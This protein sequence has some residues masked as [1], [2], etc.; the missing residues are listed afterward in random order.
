MIPHLR[1]V[2]LGADFAKRSGEFVLSRRGRGNRGALAQQIK[3]NAG[4]INARFGQDDHVAVAIKDVE[5]A[6]RLRTMR[7]RG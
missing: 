2:Q 3:F 7:E 6:E 4:I 1:L 5:S